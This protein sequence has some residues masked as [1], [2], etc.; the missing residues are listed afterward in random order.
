MKHLVSEQVMKFRSQI[1]EALEMNYEDMR[2]NM[3]RSELEYLKVLKHRLIPKI[4]RHSEETL[5]KHVAS[6]EQR[7][8]NL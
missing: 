8:S 1:D 4:N 6:Q 5:K 3:T 7:I 2:K